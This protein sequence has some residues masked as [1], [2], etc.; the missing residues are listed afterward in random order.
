MK[1]ELTKLCDLG[2]ISNAEKSVE[3]VSSLVIVEKPNGNLRLCLDPIY[4]NQSIAKD[5]FEIPKFEDLSAKLK[6]ARYFS[7]LDLKDSF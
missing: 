3:W 1:Y 2:I 4:L 7:E 5:Y 6:N